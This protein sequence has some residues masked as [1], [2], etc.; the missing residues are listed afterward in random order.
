V[1]VNPA[2]VDAIRQHLA[3]VNTEYVIAFDRLV[4][5]AREQ[6]DD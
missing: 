6:G 4:E 3:T 1:R 2:Y 5:R